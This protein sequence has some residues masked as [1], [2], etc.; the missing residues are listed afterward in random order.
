MV[1][2][3]RGRPREELATQLVGFTGF[4]ALRRGEAV[5]D[6]V[7][8]L[9]AVQIDP[10][11]VVAPAHLWSLSLR[12]GPTPVETLSLAL[13]AGTVLEAYCHARCLVATTDAG[14]MV[15][16]W[17]RRRASNRAARYHVADEA[18]RLM[19]LMEREPAVLSRDI[20]SERRIAGYWDA[21]DMQRTKATSVA[22]EILWEEGRVAVTSRSGGQKAYRLLA[23]HLPQVDHLIERLGD[24]EANELAVRHSLRT[25][26]VLTPDWPYLSWGGLSPGERKHWWQTA[27]AEGWV[28]PVAMD[29]VPLMATPEVLD[30]SLVAPRQARLLAPVDNLLWH[31]PRLEVVFGF[32]YRWEAYTPAARRKVG[33]YN[34]PILYGDRFWGQADAA[35]K[36]GQFTADLM[37]GTPG[38]TV[39]RAV[40][41]AVDRAGRLCGQLRRLPS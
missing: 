24:D 23:A 22:L 4:R 19:A 1:R 13:A 5:A 16:G 7:S 2:A 39:P 30:Q 14:A 37:A 11:Q 12:R 32:R 36:A 38:R 41:E 27:R 15:R 6:T 35:W 25:M 28:V 34:M 20:P 21:E 26:G 17:R 33:A 9:G 31:R 18:R 8:R 29:G 40:T 10:M 3:S